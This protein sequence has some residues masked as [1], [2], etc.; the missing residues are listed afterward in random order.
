[1]KQASIVLTALALAVFAGAASAQVTLTDLGNTPATPITPTPG[2]NDIFQMN[3]AQ[4]NDGLNYFFDGGDPVGACGQTFTTGANAGGYTLTNLAIKT[5]GAG[6]GG[7]T[8]S[9]GYHLYIYSVSGATATLLATYTGTT[10]FTEQHWINCSGLSV[11]MAANTQYAY[12]F[13]RDSNGWEQLANS[14]G[15]PLAGGQIC[16]IPTTGGTITFGTAGTSD[17]TFDAGLA[18]GSAAGGIVVF[19]DLQ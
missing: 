9:Q 14:S 5:A 6:G 1:M 4:A 17:A 10:S 12:A 7:S 16:R 8:G 13:K 19:S 11:P 2:A 18:L 15:D 3:V